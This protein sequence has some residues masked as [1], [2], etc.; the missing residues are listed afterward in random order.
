LASFIRY[1]DPETGDE[2]LDTMGAQCRND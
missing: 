2:A 1:R